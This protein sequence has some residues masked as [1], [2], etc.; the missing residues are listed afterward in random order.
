[1]YLVSLPPVYFAN[2]LVQ[3]TTVNAVSEVRRAILQLT[4][5]PADFDEVMFTLVNVLA[6]NL[7]D[8]SNIEAIVED[9]FVQVCLLVTCF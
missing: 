1:M 9:L 2:F 4:S 6:D 7:C 3:K 8:N 5:N